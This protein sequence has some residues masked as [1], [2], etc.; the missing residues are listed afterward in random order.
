[1]GNGTNPH[2]AQS[3]SLVWLLL[4]LLRSSQLSSTPV[5][6]TRY[7]V[8]QGQHPEAML[9]LQ[10][11][12]RA[13]KFSAKAAREKGQS[14][15]HDYVRFSGSPCSSSAGEQTERANSSALVTQQRF[16]GA[17]TP[18]V[19]MRADAP[20]AGRSRRY[21][22]QGVVHQNASSTGGGLTR[23]NPCAAGE[24]MVWTS[25]GD[26]ESRSHMAR[27]KPTDVRAGA[28]TGARCKARS[29][30]DERERLGFC[31]WQSPRSEKGMNN[32]RRGTADD[33]IAVAPAIDISNARFHR[34]G[35]EITVITPAP[36]PRCEVDDSCWNGRGEAG[37][38]VLQNLATSTQLDFDDFDGGR[39]V[40]NSG[41]SMSPIPL[42][43]TGQA[44]EGNADLVYDA[45]GDDGAHSDAA[46]AATPMLFPDPSGSKNQCG[47]PCSVDAVGLFRP[48]PRYEDFDFDFDSKSFGDNI[49]EDR[50]LAENEEDWGSLQDRAVVAAEFPAGWGKIATTVETDNNS[51][52]DLSTTYYC[53]MYL[54]ERYFQP[55][56]ARDVHGFP[57][58]RV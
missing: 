15:K 5:S 16:R 48:C 42:Q 18:T 39:N 56:A 28:A 11:R 33:S 38:S 50:R 21:P 12:S 9:D 27:S 29:I 53:D 55:S 20:A 7:L 24:D 8:G 40:Q 13:G 57:S 30:N 41:A 36:S 51:P 10:R 19:M 17:A 25:S 6:L 32:R 3:A 26:V 34:G 44:K 22:R 46:V 49:L 35:T 31:G 54:D 1:M 4:R 2:R 23:G 52:G 14:C 58:T 45:L 47:S 43:P 37:P